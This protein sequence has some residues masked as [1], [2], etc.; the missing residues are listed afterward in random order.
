MA[1]GYTWVLILALSVTN[2]VIAGKLLDP[3]EP[4]LTH[5]HNRLTLPPTWW[6]IGRIA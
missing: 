6:A 4:Q 1:V 2:T 5:L 3:S